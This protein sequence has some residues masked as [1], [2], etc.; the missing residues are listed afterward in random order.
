MCCA[1]TDS[2]RD[3]TTAAVMLYMLLHCAMLLVDASG[4]YSWLMATSGHCVLD[5]R[6]SSVTTC[7]LM[8]IWMNVAHAVAAHWPHG[9][10]RCMQVSVHQCSIIAYMQVSSQHW[11]VQV[12]SWSAVITISTVVGHSPTTLMQHKGHSP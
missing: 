10:S 3:T 2:D 11:S 7:W 9:H 12:S 5:A 8:A 1:D 6:L 4:Q